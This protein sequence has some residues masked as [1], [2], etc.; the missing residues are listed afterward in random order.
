MDALMR[1]HQPTILFAFVVIVGLARALAYA[2]T[3]IGEA[4]SLGALLHSVSLQILTFAFAAFLVASL[5][6]ATVTRA[7]FVAL[8]AQA[9]L[10]LAPF[11][12]VGLR[13]GLTDYAQTY[14]GVFGGSPGS[15]VAV[16]G[17]GAVVAWGVRDATLGPRGARTR[18]AAL[19]GIRGVG[20]VF[21]PPIPLPPLSP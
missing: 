8:Y 2:G 6:R 3:P 1:G 9:V 21:P 18:G 5:S 19:A 16:L 7:M 12:D 4:L 15:M 17:Y 11:V 14:V 10:F 13:P 20:V